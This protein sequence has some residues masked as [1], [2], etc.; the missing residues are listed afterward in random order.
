M[1]RACCLK[2]SERAAHVRECNVCV[3][4]E[5][6]RALEL[7]KC[8]H[9]LRDRSGELD[10]M[11]RHAGIGLESIQ[12]TRETFTCSLGCRNGIAHR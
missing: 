7:M 2:L 8:A 10:E 3:R 5:L 9:R 1:A 6:I 11:T 12:S 4:R